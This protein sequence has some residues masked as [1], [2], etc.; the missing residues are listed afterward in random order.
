MTTRR[1]FLRRAIWTPPVLL[2]ATAC[3]G[4][5][6]VTVTI[7]HGPPAKL[8]EVMTFTMTATSGWDAP[9]PNDKYAPSNLASLGFTLSAG[10]SSPD[11]GWTVFIAPNGKSSYSRNVVFQAKVPLTFEFQVK[12]EQPAEQ[13]VVSANA[14]VM[15]PGTNSGKATLYLKVDASGTAIQDN[16]FSR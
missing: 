7:D 13:H 15:D 5:S 16:P 10:L 14:G 12:L 6:G 8:G 1:T 2:L 3:G 11:S 4:G 9:S